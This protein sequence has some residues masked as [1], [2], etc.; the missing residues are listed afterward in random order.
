M[1]MKVHTVKGRYSNSFIIEEAD[2]LFVIDV[3]MGGE[4]Y[5]L[6]F[7]E[8]VLNRPREDIKL[9]VCT[10]DHADHIGGVLALARECNAAIAIPLASNS[11]LRKFRNCPTGHLHLQRT[12]FIEFFRPRMWN[13]Y[14]KPRRNV[15]RQPVQ[16]ASIPSKM[17]DRLVKPDFRMK[18]NEEIPGFPDWRVIHTPGHTWDSCCFYH[19]PTQSLITGD[20]LLG[21][22]TRNRLVT[23]AILSNPSQL[24]ASLT[25]LRK[26]H[27]LHVYPGHGRNFS[28]PGLLN[29]V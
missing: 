11:S 19:T 21:S 17:S 14:F 24:R 26:L 25:R 22:Q 23:P 2:G 28:G 1:M 13:M 5:V 15:V 16:K 7:L 8:E 10:H 27:P 18:D 12:T 3:H 6:G 29:N 4:K 9:V 20:T